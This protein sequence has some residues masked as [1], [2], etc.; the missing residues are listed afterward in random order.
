[1]GC[2]DGDWKGVPEGND[3]VDEEHAGLEEQ[4]QDQEDEQWRGDVDAASAL[5]IAGED[6]R[7]C[8][9]WRWR[10]DLRLEVWW[11]ELWW[12]EGRVAVGLEI[13]VKVFLEGLFERHD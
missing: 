10:R 7:G 12:V 4:D 11:W 8:G 3:C 6:L 13:L 5:W 1:M 9:W 2:S